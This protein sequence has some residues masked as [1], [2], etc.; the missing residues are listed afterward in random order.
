[1]SRNSL[2]AI[3]GG[4]A[5]IGAVAVGFWNLGSPARER[6]IHQDLRTVQ[7]LDRLADQIDNAWNHS[8]K[9]LPNNLD[10]IA[11]NAAQDPTTH[12]PFLYHPKQ[13]SQYELCATFLTDNGKTAEQ[14]ESPFWLHAKGDY[15]FQLDASAPPP[16]PPYSYDYY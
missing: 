6:Q 7:A 4:I 16:Q 1:M 12:A 2:A 9:V 14:N 15:C 11:A 10:R 8:N 13:S 5:V 3:A